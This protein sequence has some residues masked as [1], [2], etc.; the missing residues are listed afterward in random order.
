MDLFAHITV[1]EYPLL[2]FLFGVGAAFGAM[3]AWKLG[4]WWLHR[5][6]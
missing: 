4:S 3:L 2:S 6:R 1:E 5:D